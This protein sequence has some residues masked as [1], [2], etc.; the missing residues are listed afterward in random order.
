MAGVVSVLGVLAAVFG[1][2]IVRRL[3]LA[4]DLIAVSCMV[5]VTLLLY[6]IFMPVNRIVSLLAASLNIAGL[7]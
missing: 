6:A 7:T 4:G 2:F 3:E 1:E 5:A